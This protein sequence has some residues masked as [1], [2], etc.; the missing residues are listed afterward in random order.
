NNGEVLVP[1]EVSGIVN[2]EIISYEF[3][4]RY[5]PS[6]IQPQTD[7]VDVASTASR[8]LTVVSNAT[9]PGLLRVVL[10]GAYPME[11]DGLL[12]TSASPPSEPQEPSRRSPWRTLCS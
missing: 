12:L 11:H 4:L 7:P 5:D 3:N 9:E 2:K 1:I 6:V 10:Y 8:G